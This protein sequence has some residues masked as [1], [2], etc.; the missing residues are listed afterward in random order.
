MPFVWRDAPENADLCWVTAAFA[1]AVARGDLEDAAGWADLATE[2]SQGAYVMLMR[3]D[4][5]C[6]AMTREARYCPN[7]PRPGEQ[8]CGPHARYIQPNRADA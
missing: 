8:V 1:E 6:Q 4:G 5:G 3:E 2:V 7:P